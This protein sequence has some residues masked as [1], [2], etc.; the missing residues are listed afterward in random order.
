MSPA[1]EIIRLLNL[2]LNNTEGGYFANTYPL[3]NTKNPQCSSLYYFL[4]N[5]RCSVMHKVTDDMLY[6]FYAGKPV[7]MLLLYPKGYSP[8]SEVLTFSN[9]MAKSGKPRKII[10]GGT[11]IGSRIKSKDSWSLMGVSKAP[12]FDPK[13]YFLGDR[14]QLINEYPEQKDLIIALT[15]SS[16]TSN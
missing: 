15:N 1:S 10:P 9:D 3:L 13:N 6:H 2:Q 7:E 14:D 11:W 16:N 8:R 4:D 12:P 5:N